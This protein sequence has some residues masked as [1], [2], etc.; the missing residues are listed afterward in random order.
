M[1]NYIVSLST[2]Q[3]SS[4]PIHAGCA[5]KKMVGERENLRILGRRSILL[6]IQNSGR[7]KKMTSERGGSSGTALGASVV[8]IFFRNLLQQFIG[9]HSK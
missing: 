8:Y 5:I 4:G 2:D 3:D 1:S 6:G 7:G 9:T